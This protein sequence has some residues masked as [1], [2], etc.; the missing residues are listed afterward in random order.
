[1]YWRL[2]CV[3]S[4]LAQIS[5]HIVISNLICFK[6]VRS[7]M[8]LCSDSKPSN[9]TG[10]STQ[11]VKPGYLT[12]I[13]QTIFW[14]AWL[15]CPPLD[16]FPGTP[17]CLPSQWQSYWH[18]WIS[19]GIEQTSPVIK[20]KVHMVSWWITVFCLTATVAGMPTAMYTSLSV[21]VWLLPNALRIAQAGLWPVHHGRL[22][23]TLLPDN[24][25]DFKVMGPL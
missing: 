4:L 24:E 22:L 9:L 14:Q 19:Q 18:A 1:M 13:C 16:N 25:T 2:I 8:P 11:T 21:Y 17:D 20:F 3:S 15:D 23:A 12:G 5:L 10:T 6:D 7:E